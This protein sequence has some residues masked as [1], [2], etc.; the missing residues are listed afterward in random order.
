MRS[1]RAGVW[2]VVWALL[3]W[4]S[5]GVCQDTPPEQPPEEMGDA[6]VE[7]LE[8]LLSQMLAAETKRA[9]KEAALQQAVGAEARSALSAEIEE[10]GI[11][12]KELRSNFET[13]ASGVDR[14]QLDD[15]GDG[16]SSLEKQAT[17]LLSPLISEFQSMT[18]RTRKINELRLEEARLLEHS[19]LVELALQRSHSVLETAADPEMRGRLETV[20][21]IWQERQQQ[22]RGSLDVVRRQLQVEEAQKQDFLQIAQDSVIGFVRSRGLNLLLALLAAMTTFLLIRLA[23]RLVMGIGKKLRPNQERPFYARMLN[24]AVYLLSGLG[25]CGAFLGLLSLLGDWVL[26]SLFSVVLLAALWTAR[27]WIPG[28]WEQIRLL[29]NLG[30]VRENE[31]IVYMG[32]PWKIAALNFTVLLQNPAFAD[33]QLRLPLKDMVG[34]ISRRFGAS[35]SWFPTRVGD[36]VLLSDGTFGQVLAQSHEAVELRALDSHKQYTTADFLAAS[37]TNLSSGFRIESRFGIDYAHQAEATQAIPQKLQEALR[38]SCAGM[39][40]G[41]GLELLEVDFCE[42]GSSS[43]DYEIAAIFKGEAAQYW[44]HIPEDLQR[45]AVDAAIALDLTIPFPQL[46]VHKPS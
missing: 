15:P 42:A 17:K 25:A 20:V 22:L 11:K 7:S 33:F 16:D 24:V 13:I 36:F 9:E 27:E 46:V 1:A 44:E 32:V 14:T 45:F 18:K 39:P 8:R 4:G 26:L 34:R 10:L 5:G 40:Y 38:E 28:A 31:R 21:E 6:T 30:S 2:L 19:Q 35:E 23:Y 41:K 43:L 37:P 12:L 29:L 3:G